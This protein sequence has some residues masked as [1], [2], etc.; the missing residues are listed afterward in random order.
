MRVARFRRYPFPTVLA[1]E[2]SAAPDTMGPLVGDLE[3]VLGWYSRED[4]EHVERHVRLCELLAD[5]L[6]LAA[7]GQG[8]A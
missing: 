1:A 2:R 6:E 3:H 7:D 5:A 8:A 4:R